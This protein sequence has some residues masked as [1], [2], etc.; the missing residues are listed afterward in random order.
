[1]SRVVSPNI[2]PNLAS[3]GGSNPWLRADFLVYF[4]VGEGVLLQ[5]LFLLNLIDQHP[6]EL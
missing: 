5:V 3:A 6:V 1:M 4:S 2:F